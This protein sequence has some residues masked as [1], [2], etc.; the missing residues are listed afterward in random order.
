MIRKNLLERPYSDRRLIMFVDDEVIEAHEKAEAAAIESRKITITT[1]E[2]LEYF[3]SQFN[4]IYIDDLVRMLQQ[5]RV[6][7]AAKRDGVLIRLVEKSL[8]GQFQLL[9][10]HPRDNV[11]Y[12]GHPAIPKYYIPLAEFHQVIFQHK[13]S[14][15]LS[16]LMNLG[17]KNIHVR[18]VKGL[19][20]EHLLNQ[21]VVSAVPIKTEAA[22]NRGRAIME[23]YKN[24]LKSSP[25]GSAGFDDVKVSIE[26]VVL[27][28]TAPRMVQPPRLPFNMSWYM[29][30]PTW[31]WVGEGR[32]KFGLKEFIV[33][34]NSP[35]DYD[36]NLA[37]RTKLEKAGF[38]VGTEFARH[39]PTLWRIFG[40]FWE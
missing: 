13:F 16:M 7:F 23:A 9:P 2:Y 17:A 37:L 11:L 5:A 14:E 24:M 40:E 21:G 8:I 6:Y 28:R 1:E 19:G 35:E 3:K 38:N 27:L 31:Q 4:R 30:E 22:E 20:L 15:A 34:L 10:G 33:D 39:V 18:Y 29:F 32:M 25:I 26:Q 12:V 36:I